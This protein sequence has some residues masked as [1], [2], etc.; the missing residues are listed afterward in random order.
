L[1]EFFLCIMSVTK[2]TKKSRKD[3]LL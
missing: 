1:Q 3:I 2:D